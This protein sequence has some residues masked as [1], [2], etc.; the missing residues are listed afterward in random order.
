[1]PAAWL[2]QPVSRPL[3]RA[4][5]Y[6]FSHAGGGASAYRLWP[7]GL[8]ASLD[9]AAVQLPGREGRLREP[10][11]A[12]IPAIVEALLPGL[13]AHLDRPF[14]FFGHS[15]GAIVASELARALEATG[16]PR[17]LHLFV[18][19]R[20]PPHV[21]DPETPLH[22]LPDPAFVDELTHRYGGI[23]A[24][25]LRHADLM[26]LLLPAIRADIRA[27]ETFRP[28]PRAPLPVPVSAFGGAD[29]RRTP[30]AHLEAWA[31]V[32][33]SAFRVRVFPGAHFYLEAC[34]D[35]VLADLAACLAPALDAPP[36][37]EATA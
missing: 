11:Y 33:S 23:P 21:P 13:R 8:P 19:G 17:P 29:D 35:A 5:L 28:A 18:S 36:A 15:M 25:I 6:C 4:R 14:A 9:V 37:S 3:A 24:E 32:T 31:G 7:A 10:P 12:S 16:G 26:E 30:R 22:V 2:L 27:L 1:M 34:R 20:R